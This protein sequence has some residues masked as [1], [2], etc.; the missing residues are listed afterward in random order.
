MTSINT[1]NILKI[2]YIYQ[3]FPIVPVVQTTQRFGQKKLLTFSIEF[4]I[5]LVH[6]NLI[7]QLLII[8]KESLN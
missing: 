4:N 8:I 6:F 5:T 3:T 7:I 2:S 1:I